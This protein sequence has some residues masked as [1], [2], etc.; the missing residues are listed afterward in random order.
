MNSKNKNNPE[1]INQ[2]NSK[3]GENGFRNISA[4]VI[5]NKNN[6][7]LL[8]QQRPKETKWNPDVWGFFGG[9]FENNETKEL[10]AIREI[11]EET[12]LNLNINKLKYI[13]MYIYENTNCYFFYYFLEESELKHFK[14][15]EGQDFCWKSYHQ[16]L[17]LDFGTVKNWQL[18]F[19]NNEIKNILKIN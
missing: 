19:L 6:K 10:C 9:K 14:L 7:K 16:S 15:Q 2:K 12:N 11:K 5:I 8:F 13:N 3:Y 18:N 1:K 17:E 4:V